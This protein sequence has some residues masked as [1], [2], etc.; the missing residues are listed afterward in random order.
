MKQLAV[1]LAALLSLMLVAPAMAQPFADVPTDH[2]AYDAIAE[3]AAKGLIEGYPDGAFRGDRAMTRYEMAMVVARLLARIE[4]IKIPPLPPDLVRRGDLAPITKDI[5]AARAAATAE[6]AAL[7]KKFTASIAT[8]NRLIAE[9]RAELAALGVRVTA[10]EEELAALKARVDNTRVTGDARFRFNLFPND[11]PSGGGAAGKVP[12]AR[13]RT[14]LTFTGTVAPNV[15]AVV[16]LAA[17]NASNA[18][19]I[20]Y[21]V[22]LGH[23][24][25]FGDVSF[26]SA[27]V[28]VRNY[29]GASLWRAGRQFFTL[30]GVGF[31]GV[32]LLYD[33]ANSSAAGVYQPLMTT[34][35]TTP[36][37]HWITNLPY[38]ITMT[39]LSDGLRTDWVLGPFNLTAAIFREA[40]FSIASGAGGNPSIRD[41]R[42]L[43][44][45]TGALLPGWT[46][47]GTYF[48]EH[49]LHTA[50]AATS[51]GVGTSG[52]TGWGFDLAGTLMPGIRVYGE[53]TNWNTSSFNVG[54]VTAAQNVKAWRVGGNIDLARLAGITTWRPNLDIEYR[55][56]GPV[57][58]A[59]F[60]FAWGST[61]SA[62]P[63]QVC[64]P[65]TTYATTYTGQAYAYN[66]KG[67][68]A[69]LNLTISPTTT[70]WFIYDTGQTYY[71]SSDNQYTEYW[72]RVAHTLARN[73]TISFNYFYGKGPTL[74]LT[75]WTAGTS[76][77]WGYLNQEY[78][79]FY[80]VELTYS[81]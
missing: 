21:D 56:Y 6:S 22:R 7:D 10:V 51:A 54:L 78:M 76:P 52:G 23:N 74:Q 61:G 36:A 77:S 5:A 2:W 9:F 67:W 72:F 11:G 1:V 34:G 31:A 27:F 13:I 17:N 69:R 42:V 4:A 37:S 40:N 57:D 60:A 35:V 3:L 81:W 41:D 65:S 79:K 64:Y 46:L 49:K 29:L 59:C 55:D 14:R 33:P 8:I 39:G 18:S 26:D 48:A 30:A 25:A 62:S 71:P 80:R 43:R 58:G 50:V 70:A 66:M 63:W 28:D 20:N 68:L 38:S 19:G 73:T 32:G 12:D 44:V 75:G 47:G 24:Y 15:T 53:Y 45:T 16:R